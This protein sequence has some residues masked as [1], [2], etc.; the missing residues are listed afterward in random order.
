MRLRCPRSTTV[1]FT[2]HYS[3]AYI[4]DTPKR[5][6]CQR[7][8][9]NILRITFGRTVSKERSRS[10]HGASTASCSTI[11][12]NHYGHQSHFC[13][14]PIY[15]CK[16][17]GD[18]HQGICNHMRFDPFPID[19]RRIGCRL[20]QSNGLDCRTSP[21]KCFHQRTGTPTNNFPPSITAPMCCCT[22]LFRKDKVK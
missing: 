15:T 22:P 19:H 6:E 2:N 8:R 1:V 7:A 16:R 17:P 4:L 10:F 12:R 13:T 14:L 18:T 20:R 3:K 5:N 21:R 11:I 9:S